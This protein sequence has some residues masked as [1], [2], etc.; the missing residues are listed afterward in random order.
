M[1][2]LTTHQ[3][4]SL[5]G[6]AN[7]FASAAALRFSN[8]S[9]NADGRLVRLLDWREP[10]AQASL[11]DRALRAF[12]LSDGFSCVAG[13]AAISTAGYRFGY[14]PGLAELGATEG[15]ARDLAAFVAE[16]PSMQSNYATF[17]AVFEELHCGDEGWF[18]AN[19]WAQLQ[20]LSDLSMAYYPWD[21]TVSSDPEA[22]DFGFSFAGQAFFV[23]GLHPNSSRLSRRFFMPA[24]AFNAHRQF[25]DA[26]RTGRFAR[27]Q[28]LVRERELALQGSLNPELAPFGTR[29]EARQYSG[30]QKQE[31]W[32]CPFRARS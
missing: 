22:P 2:V 28:A 24:I 16:R 20:R 29:S 31:G 17:I 8:Y 27:I 25:A 5:Y 19:L 11:A 6:T 3:A 32:K 13:K 9:A 1:D 14:Y 10:T 23:V 21:S 7:P 26:R 12:I 15:L 4:V 18:E 30:R